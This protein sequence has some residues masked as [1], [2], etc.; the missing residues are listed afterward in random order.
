MA[1][2]IKKH[3]DLVLVGGIGLTLAIIGVLIMSGMMVLPNFASAATTVQASVGV[4]A[5]VSEWLTF[6]VSTSSVT[7]TPDLVSI[8]GATAIAS[9][10]IIDLNLGTNSPNGWSMS[11]TSTNGQL[12][13]SAGGS[14]NSPATGNT[15]TTAAGTDA[16]GINAT[17]TYGT[18][19]I[20]ALYAEATLDSNV[21]GSVDTSSQSFATSS[22]IFADNTNVIDIRVRASC[23]ALQEPG[24]YTDT[25]YLTAT[26]TP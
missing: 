19:S 18:I 24:S 25:I 14:I 11:V 4:T 1:E 5:T 15:T 23:D 12:N 16:Y 8:T 13:G 21:V 26:A 22:Q 17:T 6:T 20:P 7:L 3:W 10:S 9:S 2:K